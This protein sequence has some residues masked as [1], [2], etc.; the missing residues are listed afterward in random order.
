MSVRRIM[1]IETE[2]G[3]TDEHAAHANPVELSFAVVDAAATLAG[4]RHIRWDYSGEDPVNDARGYRL[5]RANARPDMLTDA[6]QR[7][8]VNTIAAN[9]GRIY[10]DHAH[11]EYSS[12]E[13]TGPLAALA[14]DR[15]GDRMMLAAARSTG[16]PIGLYRNNVDGKGAS[17]GSHESYQVDRAVPFDTLVA[18]MTPHFVTRQLYTGTGRVGLGERGETSG[19]Q[20]S[21]RADYFHMRVGLQTTFDRPIVNTR[22]ESHSVPGLRRL[23]VIVGDANRAD[24]P[25]AL[26]LGVTSMLLWTA[27][28]AGAVGYDLGALT[29]ALALADPV[30]AI[31]AVSHD[32]TLATPLAL[33]DGATTTAWA[34]QVRLRAAVYDVAARVHGTDITGEPLWPDPETR[35]IMALWGQALED[36][37]RV[38]H[39]DDDE[40]LGMGAAATR[41][42]WLLKWQV[43]EGLRR[44]GGRDWSASALAAVDIAWGALEPDRSIWAKVAS[45]STTLADDAAIDAAAHAP[46]DTRAWLREALVERFGAHAVAASWRSATLRRADG[47][48]ATIDMSDGTRF[49]RSLWEATLAGLAGTEA[50][51]TD[52]DALD[53]DI[54]MVLA[55][56]AALASGD[57]ADGGAGT[58][59]GMEDAGLPRVS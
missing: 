10:V 54:D 36:L 3:V 16:R 21:Q 46:D 28:H 31:H 13:T 37:A 23:H 12:P 30:A 1:G 50:W 6:P 42:E 58:G 57:G 52:P 7:Q 19:F 35:T 9:G 41:L 48:L 32:L 5:E 47:S 49:V 11:P 33:E 20:L 51:D 45:R 59:A 56:A 38:R 8:I 29:G 15:A 43:L 17:W 22:D 34:I 39:D 27:E 53:H 40:R 18:L 26:K 14:A 55:R 4:R 2:Y 44:K 25:E 24:V